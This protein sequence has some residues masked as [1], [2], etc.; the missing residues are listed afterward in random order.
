MCR[1]DPE[2]IQ[3][4]VDRLYVDPKKQRS[5]FIRE[6]LQEADKRREQQILAQYP[7][8]HAPMITTS[9]STRQKHV[10]VSPERIQRLVQHLHDES[11]TQKQNNL[12]LD[13]I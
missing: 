12:T 11:C 2:E 5:Q 9:S 6:Y 10:G 8:G 4:A 13:R 7:K 3:A 1:R